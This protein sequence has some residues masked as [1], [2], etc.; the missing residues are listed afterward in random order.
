MGLGRV[1]A[2]PMATSNGLVRNACIAIALLGLAV[3]ATPP[4]AAICVGSEPPGWKFDPSCVAVGLPPSGPVETS[5]VC[6]DVNKC[7][8]PA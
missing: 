5:Y 8:P 1:G 6:V 4:A 2:D 3:V 7:L